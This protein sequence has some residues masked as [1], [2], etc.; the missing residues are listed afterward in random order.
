MD[1]YFNATEN[2][3]AL[4]IPY[5]YYKFMNSPYDLKR[6]FIQKALKKYRKGKN[7]VMIVPSESCKSN[8]FY[9]AHSRKIA[10][11]KKIFNGYDKKLKNQYLQCIYFNQKETIDQRK[12]S[13]NSGWIKYKV[14]KKI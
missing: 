2:A 5:S 9:E 3:G 12:K 14:R 6:I 11:R 10:A 1:P 7:I 4:N 8:D 13:I